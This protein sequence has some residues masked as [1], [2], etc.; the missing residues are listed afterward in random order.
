MPVKLSYSKISTY[1][2]CPRKYFLSYIAKLGTGSSPH[3]S[4]GS[5]IHKCCED[6][7]DFDTDKKSEILEQNFTEIFETPGRS[8]E[9]LI[10]YYQMILPKIDK[11]F[12]VHDNYDGKIVINPVFE[13]K[14]VKALRSFYEDY[15]Q[16]FYSQNKKGHGPLRDKEATSPEIKMQEQWFNLELKDGHEIRGLID[17]VDEEPQGEHIVDYKSGQ[18]R[19]TFKALTDALDI[20]AMQLSIYALARYKETGKVPY[21]ASFF[22]L[23]PLKNGK[24][25]KGEYRSSVDFNPEKLEKVEE[26][27]NDI[28]NEIEEATNN[29]EFPTGDNPNCYWC[30]FNKKCEILAERQ[31]TE[32]NNSLKLVNDTEDE[33]TLDNSIWEE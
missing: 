24:T 15:E 26:F 8:L 13:V 4:N 6:Y 14:A 29:K 28:A 18:T 32:M 21:K 10:K 25:D 11:E 2:D 33:V 9:N 23:E 20:K 5:A 12:L 22:Y 7:E 31:I 16:N 19:I 27:L 1:I 30:D 17:R 3:M